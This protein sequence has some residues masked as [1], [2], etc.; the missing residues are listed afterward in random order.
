MA[1]F[2]FSQR[3]SPPKSQQSQAHSQD[4]KPEYIKANPRLDGK[5]VV[6]GAT[7][8]TIYVEI[9]ERNGVVCSNHLTPHDQLRLFKHGL[10]QPMDLWYGCAEDFQKG[11]AHIYRLSKPIDIDKVFGNDPWFTFQGK[12]YDAATEPP[13]YKCFIRGVVS[14]KRFRDDP[15]S[16][17]KWVRIEGAKW[18]VDTKVIEDFLSHF[19]QLETQLEQKSSIFPMMIPMEKVM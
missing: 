10:K 3:W 17:L 9:K 7:R 2:G 11:P 18:R 1:F 14:N 19:G 13:T 12:T 16:T 6:E 15:N 4:V 5:G 8:N